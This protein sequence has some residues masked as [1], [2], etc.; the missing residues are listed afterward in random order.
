M[1]VIETERKISQAYNIGDIQAII[2][3]KENLLQQREKLNRWFD[4]Y[5]DLFSNGMEK[6]NKNDPVWKLYDK[7]FATYQE[8]SHAITTANYFLEK[9]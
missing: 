7:K 9:S 8:V 3:E 2:S 4:R 6:L 1:N 5:L